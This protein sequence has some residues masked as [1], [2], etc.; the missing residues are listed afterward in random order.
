MSTATWPVNEWLRTEE[1]PAGQS[2]FWTSIQ[3]LSHD[4]HS[5]ALGCVMSDD[6][7]DICFAS[8]DLRE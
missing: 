3:L 2:D 7:Y 5:V 8:F 1:M 6:A 4:D